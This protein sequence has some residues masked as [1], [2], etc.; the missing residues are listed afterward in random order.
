ML[1]ENPHSLASRE[2]YPFVFI[3]A[4]FIGIN[5]DYF[6]LLYGMCFPKKQILWSWNQDPWGR[7]L[8]CCVNLDK[9]C[10]LWGKGMP[11]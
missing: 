8:V 11:I 3:F 1:L 10:P 6:H 9:S 7:L 2:V 5:A 4:N